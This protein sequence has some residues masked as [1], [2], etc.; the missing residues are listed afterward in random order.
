MVNRPTVTDA[1]D[2]ISVPT[3]M[4]EPGQ[5]LEGRFLL[6]RRLGSGGA[7]VVFSARDTTVNQRVAIKVLHPHVVDD[8]S[9]ERVRREVRASR[10]GHPN[11]VTIFELYEADGLVFLAMELV[12]GPNLGEILKDRDR[13][14][15]DEVI[16][17]GR[18]LAAA[19][20]H[21]AARGLVHRDVKPGN[22]LL[23]KDGIAK[24]CDTGLVRPTTSG[25]TVTESAM[26][27]GTPAYMAPE[28][29]SG[30]ELTPAA[31]VY[32]LGLTL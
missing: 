3:P 12:E 30:A 2:L 7:G 17:L 32:A 21:L 26:V 11:A 29:A 4:P 9:R 23:G 1:P 31:D 16:D 13:L 19:L 18:E 6:E 8:R 15:I 5:I 22:V 24:L 27:V 28:Q 25:E 20:A 10:P 14:T